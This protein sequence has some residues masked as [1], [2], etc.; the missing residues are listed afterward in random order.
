MKNSLKSVLVIPVLFVLFFAATQVSSGKAEEGT[1]NPPYPYA[2]TVLTKPECY[3]GGCA[4]QNT[5]T[6]NVLSVPSTGSSYHLGSWPLDAGNYDVKVCCDGMYGTAN[7]TINPPTGGA[8][9]TIELHPGTCP[10][11]G[12]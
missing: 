8:Y 5:A 6:L 3:S 9:I 12:N 11:W 7:V 2:I 1:K 4:I 10:D